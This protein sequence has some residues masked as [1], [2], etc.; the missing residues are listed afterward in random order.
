ML[1]IFPEIKACVE[2]GEIEKLA[3][4]IR[5]YFGGAMAKKPKLCV[6]TI[7]ECFGLHV[8]SKANLEYMGVTLVDDNNGKF[9]VSLI[10]RED[11]SKLEKSFLLAHMLGHFLFDIQQGLVS[12]ELK[13]CGIGESISPLVR[14]EQNYYPD[15]KNNETVK[16]FRADLFAASLLMPKA[17]FSKACKLLH[18]D[19]VIAN[20]FGTSEASVRRRKLDLSTKKQ[21]NLNKNKINPMQISKNMKH[22]K[23]NNANKNKDVVNGS[24]KYPVSKGQAMRTN[25]KS[26]ESENSSGGLKRLREIARMLDKSVKL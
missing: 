15:L 7:I 11:L 24:D 4:T 10:I 18:Q 16:E 6:D 8:Q 23:I 2:E 5:L 9:E 19:G 14:Y 26:Q 3:V 1:A 25:P 12:N 21:G 13:S 22:K 20:V 17:M